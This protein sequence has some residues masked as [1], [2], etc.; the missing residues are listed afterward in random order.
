MLAD[1][2]GK[3]IQED[4]M[5]ERGTFIVNPKERIVVYEVNYGSIG[6][7]AEELLR[8]I[9][10]AKFVAEHGN[11]VC[12]ARWKPGEKMLTSDLNL[13]GKLNIEIRWIPAGFFLR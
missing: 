4:G 6:R 5:V 10:A 12:P 1:P 8:K 11:Q 13:V 7:N 3:L 2:T 9:Q